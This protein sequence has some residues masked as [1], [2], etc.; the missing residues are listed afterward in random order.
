MN[1]TK[2]DLRKKIDEL[3]TYRNEYYNNNNS[4]ISDHEDKV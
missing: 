2:E 3:N 1:Y 4:I